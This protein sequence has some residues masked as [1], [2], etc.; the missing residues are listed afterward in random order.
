MAAAAGG[1]RRRRGRGRD[2]V[3]GDELVKKKEFNPCLL[4]GYGSYRKVAR[5]RGGP[6]LLPLSRSGTRVSRRIRG[7][8]LL[9]RLA[10]SVRR[11]S[12]TIQ[13]GQRSISVLSEF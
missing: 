11:M 10:V 4:D 6:D 5:G 1:D 8:G 3:G 7:D 9:S 2:A 13:T 12:R